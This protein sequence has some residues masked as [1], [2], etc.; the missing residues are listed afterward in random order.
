MSARWHGGHPSWRPTRPTAALVRPAP[1]VQRFGDVVRHVVQR[2]DR[3]GFG[4]NRLIAATLAR[5]GWR[6]SRE[7]VR[8]IRQER[9]IPRAPTLRAARPLIPRDPNHVWFLDLTTIA[10]AWAP[11]VVDLGYGVRWRHAISRRRA[12]VSAGADRG[13][14]ADAAGRRD[15]ATRSAARRRHRSRLAVHGG[16]LSEGGAGARDPASLRRDRPDGIHRADRAGLAHPQR[17]PGPTCSIRRASRRATSRCARRSSGTAS[18][19]R[20]RRS[21]ARRPVSR[22]RHLAQTNPPFTRYVCL[23]TP[24]PAASDRSTAR[25]ETSRLFSWPL[26]RENRAGRPRKSGRQFPVGPYIA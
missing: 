10:G 8:R 17:D 23:G 26:A 6:L 3:M 22:G 24:P 15:R 5:A 16:R 2:M 11:L 12:A 4:G 19:D 1:P 14:D 20:T 13:G 7:T 25:S 9:G 18:T 21:T